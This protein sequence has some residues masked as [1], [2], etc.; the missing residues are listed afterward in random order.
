M[1]PPMLWIAPTVRTV[2]FALTQTTESNLAFWSSSRSYAAFNA[3]AV[4]PMPPSPRI[5]TTGHG[6]SIAFLMRRSSRP[7]PKKPV[8]SK[9]GIGRLWR[10]SARGSVGSWMVSPRTK[11]GSRSSLAMASLGRRI[12]RAWL[13]ELQRCRARSQGDR[14]VVNF[15]WARVRHSVSNGYEAFKLR[16]DCFKRLTGWFYRSRPCLRAGS[17]RRQRS[18]AR[19]ERGQVAGVLVERRPRSKRPEAASRACLGQVD[20]SNSDACIASLQSVSIA[21]INAKQV[22]RVALKVMLLFTSLFTDPEVQ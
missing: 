2:D 5:E 19:T 20:S 22:S 9:S 14:Q 18:L 8:S 10:D 11:A 7:R 12:P 21:D 13:G 6:P 4:F 16:S 3:I 15:H 17:G 1:A